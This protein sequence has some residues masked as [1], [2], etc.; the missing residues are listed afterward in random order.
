[1]PQ[2]SGPAVRTIDQ[3]RTLAPRCHPASG[4]NDTVMFAPNGDVLQ[5]I[6]SAA[7]ARPMLVGATAAPPCHA[8]NVGMPTDAAT[9][10]FSAKSPIVKEGSRC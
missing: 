6:R 8:C 5:P 3:L 4:A 9:A 10:Q 2:V 7:P 1:M